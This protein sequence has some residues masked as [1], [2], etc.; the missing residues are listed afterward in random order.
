VDCRWDAIA[1]SVDDRTPT[2]RGEI[3][4]GQVAEDGSQRPYMAGGGEKDHVVQFCV[5]KKWNRLEWMG[6]E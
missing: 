2:E 4:E 6:M 5:Q 1:Q 3:P